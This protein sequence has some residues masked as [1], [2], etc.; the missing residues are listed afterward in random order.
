MTIVLN[1]TTGISGVDGSASTPS[2]Q[3]NDTNTGIFYP[4]ADTI[5]FA[6][7]GVEAMRI[8]S[9]GNVGIGT[10][11]PFS[12]AGYKS[13][14][15][16]GS[17]TGLLALQNNG[18]NQIYL[19]S[20]GSAFNFKGLQN[21]PL[22]FYTNDTYRMRIDSSGRP[23]FNT[24]SALNAGYMSLL[25]DGSAYNGF[26]LKTSY[27]TLGSVYLYFINSAG[28][29]AGYVTQNGT[30]TVNYVT[31]SD[32]RMKENVVPITNALDRVA[33][34]KPVTYIWKDTNNEQGEG[35]IAHELQEVCPLAVS[36]EKDAVNEDGTIKPQGIDTSKLVATL[37]AAI[38]EQ[39]AIINDLKARVTALEA[40]NV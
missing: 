14:T 5:A 15:I 33:K 6:E 19:Y 13:L 23:L 31:S 2:F 34:L 32:Y 8:D 17:T 1:G 20:D 11:S 26:T 24:T 3:G 9:S 7:G 28:N 39:Q 27:A 18:T 21:I 35:F 22:D 12:A 4:A 36:G 16:N 29:V 38:Q 30:T 25:F 37:T 10:T 40:S